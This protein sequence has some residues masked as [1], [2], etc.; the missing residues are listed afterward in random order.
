MK[1]LIYKIGRMIHVF[2]P[3]KGA[4][5][6]L[7]R[8][9]YTGYC[10][11]KFK[12]IGKDSLIEPYLLAI[13]GG[14]NISIGDDCRIDRGTQLSTYS[15]RGDQCFN[16]EIIIGNGCGIG[17]YSHLTAVNGIYIGNNVRMG[18]S[19]LIT[20]N[21]HGA[22]RRDLLDMS[23]RYRPLYSKGPV[24][25]E[26]NVWIGEKSSIMPG[27]TVGR[28]AIIAAN[29]VVTH[30]VPPYSVVGGNPAKI[31]KQL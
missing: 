9:L 6:K 5:D 20:D 3:L 4:M 30:D 14:E 25:I 13:V 1:D 18:K 2:A 15:S 10:S 31:I 28:G 16:P 12:S 26:D 17:A 7:Q 24:H 8:V 23:P 21:A 29:S 19:I 22:S 27:V 11:A